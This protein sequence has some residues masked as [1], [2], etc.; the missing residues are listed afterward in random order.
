[1]ASQN[2]QQVATR[3]VMPGP[4]GL[5]MGSLVAGAM[6]LL[7]FSLATFS[8]LSAGNQVSEVIYRS[9]ITSVC[10]AVVGGLVGMVAGQ[11]IHEQFK[12]R[13]EANR[14]QREVDREQA[15]LADSATPGNQPAGGQ[16]GPGSADQKKSGQMT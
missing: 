11:V 12:A 4:A 15:R 7:G 10:L 8:G 13:S 1:M 2:K 6:G 14:R 16:S 3:P 9:L 5:R